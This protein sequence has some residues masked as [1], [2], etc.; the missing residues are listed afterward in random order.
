MAKWVVYDCDQ[1]MFL[2]CI[3]KKLTL[4]N[5]FFDRY[6]NQPVEAIHHFTSFSK[7]LLV[8]ILIDPL[9]P[10][11]TVRTFDKSH[12][13]GSSINPLPTVQPFD[14]L[15]SVIIQNSVNSLKPFQNT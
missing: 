2:D 4:A 3:D 11:P 14:K 12:L 5:I 15:L 10:L 8:A 7:L 1:S 9:K 6:F 13:A